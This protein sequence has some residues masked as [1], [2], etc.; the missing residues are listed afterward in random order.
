MRC[1]Q[2]FILNSRTAAALPTASILALQTLICKIS[3]PS[4]SFPPSPGN[5]ETGAAKAA[6]SH[7]AAENHTWQLNAGAR[8]VVSVLD[9]QQVS[10]T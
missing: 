8:K 10:K 1:A 2:F 9:T 3:F 5:K 7:M 6:W 4:L